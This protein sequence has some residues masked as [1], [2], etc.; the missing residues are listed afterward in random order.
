[1]LSFPMAFIKS[2]ENG[3]RLVSPSPTG[4]GRQKKSPLLRALPKDK[5]SRK[6]SGG[7]R[8]I[9]ILYKSGVFSL[10]F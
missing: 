1:M 7:K 9:S 6:R 8:H 4:C 10:L 3:M 2:T 5:A